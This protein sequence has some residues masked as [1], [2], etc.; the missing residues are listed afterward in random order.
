MGNEHT[1]YTGEVDVPPEAIQVVDPVVVSSKFFR[2]IY[3]ERGEKV[4]N[5]KMIGHNV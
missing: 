4:A 3:S 1:D 2:L 5:Q